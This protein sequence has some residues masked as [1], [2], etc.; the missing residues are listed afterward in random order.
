MQTHFGGTKAQFPDLRGVI[1]A[2]LFL[3]MD[4]EGVSQPEVE[5]AVLYLASKDLKKAAGF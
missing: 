4:A 1:P 3:P 2:R 5:D